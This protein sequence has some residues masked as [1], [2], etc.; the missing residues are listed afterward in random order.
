MGVVH[1]PEF[2]AWYNDSFYGRITR[3]VPSD[4]F[5]GYMPPPLDGIWATGPFLHNGSVPTIELV[6]NSK[7]RPAV[8]KRVDLDDT[9]FDEEALGWPWVEVPYPQAS[10]PDDEKKFIYDTSY[11]SQSNAG[12][13]FG[14]RLSPEERR[15]VIEYLKT[16]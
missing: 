1:A 11:W 10:A 15:A 2:V 9:H 16:L 12:H 13:T 8:W 14:D 7:A 5:P 6:L 3:I 4:P